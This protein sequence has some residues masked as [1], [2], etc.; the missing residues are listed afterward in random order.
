MEDD[1][2]RGDEEE[3]NGEDEC[4]E[5]VSNEGRSWERTREADSSV[6]GWQCDMGRR[7]ALASS[8]H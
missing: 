8:A 7:S 6:S 5:V 2:D 4:E 1:E 3:E